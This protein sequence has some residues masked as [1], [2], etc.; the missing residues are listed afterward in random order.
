MIDWVHFST[1]QYDRHRLDELTG[2][3]ASLDTDTGELGTIR[4]KTDRGRP[5][6]INANGVLR[7][8]FSLHQWY[9]DGTNESDYTAD[10]IADTLREL[11]RLWGI[12]PGRCIL[13]ALEYGANLD[14]AGL[15]FGSLEF[16][17][18]LVYLQRRGGGKPFQWM[19]GK[20]SRSGK[21]AVFKAYRFK[22]YAKGYQLRN[23]AKYAGSAVPDLLRLEIHTKGM[24]RFKQRG[25]KVATLAD[26]ATPAV[27]DELRGELLRVYAQIIVSTPPDADRL[28]G[29]S[30]RDQLLLVE[31]QNPA[32]WEAG[33]RASTSAA[34][35]ART[36]W[37]KLDARC[38]AHPTHHLVGEL[39]RAKTAALIGAPGVD[40]SGLSKPRVAPDRIGEVEVEPGYLSPP[41]AR[42]HSTKTGLS[43]R[44]GSESDRTPRTGQSGLSRRSSIVLRKPTPGPAF[45]DQLDAAG[46]AHLAD[47]LTERQ[48]AARAA[49]RCVMCGVELRPGTREKVTCGRVCRNAKSNAVND[50]L[51]Q[52][53]KRYDRGENVTDLLRRIDPATL[54]AHKDRRARKMSRA[55]MT[56]ERPIPDL[57]DT[58]P[59]PELDTEPI[60]EPTDTPPP[61][62]LDEPPLPDSS[63]GA[64]GATYRGATVADQ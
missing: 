49:G 17:R 52:L 28:D 38:A 4:G 43:K 26:L 29:L 22:A 2:W 19:D 11:T 20:A 40:A 18:R 27:L 48:R 37:K 39:L 9:N 1:D 61:P 60:P 62:D 44:F 53:R 32:F 16:V 31:G 5:L 47:S 25:A 34:T 10:Q 6:S 12:E 56:R 24:D 55:R 46:I 57:F 45:A 35:R 13:H 23:A 63:G 8:R 51:K 3:I 59:P 14:T 36:R 50:A 41:A 15:P 30:H 7:V 58:P 42:A 64:S 54:D 21:D 33:A